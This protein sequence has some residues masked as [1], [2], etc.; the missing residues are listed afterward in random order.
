MIYVT[1]DTHGDMK[2]FSD[3]RI[4]QLRKGDTL[5]VCGDF[6]FIWA[7]GKEEEACLKK[8]SRK[9]YNI[10]FVDG[11]HE[12]FNRLNAYPVAEWNGG[13][14]HHICG[15]IYHLM[16][17]QIY[18]IERKTLFAMGGGESPDFDIRVENNS[19]SR[20]ETPNA[21]EL[22]E[23]AR[24]LEE[25]NC[26][27]DYIL[28]HEPPMKI[29]GFLSLKDKEPVRVTGLNTYFEE[30]RNACSYERWFFGSMHLDKYVSSSCI[31]VFQ[32]VIDTK[33]GEPV[34]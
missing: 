31:A 14:V 27:V 23:G 29:K 5:L 6:G 34:R 28:T 26:H 12:D 2:R 17:G 7:G 8:L 25:L 11:T 19:W 1:G 32:N 22:L 4:K 9:K 20:Q 21:N 10:C 30:L 18:T 3:P 13:K 33:T 24:N 15:N 16:R